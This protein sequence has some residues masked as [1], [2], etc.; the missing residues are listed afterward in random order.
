VIHEMGDRVI[1][2]DAIRIY[3]IIEMLRNNFQVLE[4]KLPT[5]GRKQLSEYSS[6]RKLALNILPFHK[7]DD[8]PMSISSDS[9]ATR[10]KFSASL[11]F[12]TRTLR[13]LKPDIL[14]A[15]SPLAGWITSLAASKLSMRYIIDV[16]GLTF[17]EARGRGDKNWQQIMDIESTA[18]ENCDYLV[19]VSKKMKEYLSD[20]FGL[21][22]SKIAV[23]PNGCE[24]Q[25]V[26]AKYKIP[27][28]VIY[29]GNFSYYEK[30][31][32][33]LEVAKAANPKIFKFYLCG[34]GPLKNKITEKIR[35]ERIPINY[36]GYIPRQWI[37]TL[38]SKMQIGLV[39]STTDIAR[40]VACPIKV[41]DY[42]ACGL[43]VITPNVGDW[44]ELIEKEDCGIRIDQNFVEEYSQA[45]KAL[46]IES[47]WRKAADN[48]SRVA[49]EQCSWNKVLQPLVSLVGSY[50]TQNKPR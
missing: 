34:A 15:E 14:L 18:F 45:L 13:K 20:E 41:F 24:P 27:L 50:H 48:A 8:L 4:V 43:P 47:N 1:L 35:K 2:G 10:L 29:A 30:V 9:M 44:G 40:K 46:S 21:S 42:L 28:K 37:Y 17:A 11:N 49:K 38:L 32:D 31:D 12:L 6:L 3:R 7:L 5:I 39:P 26:V 16:H 22:E 19:V 25:E 36:L 23:A 33:L